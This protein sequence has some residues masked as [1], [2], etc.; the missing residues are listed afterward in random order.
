MHQ[1]PSNAS[2]FVFVLLSAVFMAVGF[3]SIIAL[4]SELVNRET[5]T[6]KGDGDDV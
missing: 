6:K 3:T 1:A 2:F 5:F 4:A